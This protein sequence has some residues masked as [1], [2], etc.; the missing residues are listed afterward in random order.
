MSTLAI[1]APIFGGSKWH[2]DYYVGEI[3]KLVAG[4]TGNKVATYDIEGWR[5]WFK[6]NFPAHFNRMSAAET[7]QAQLW[8]NMSPSAQAEFKRVVKVELEA[9]SFA[10]E[11]FINQGIG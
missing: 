7:R 5:E 6:E 9:Y 8:G 1:A 10:I 2:T 3:R 4:E 11:K